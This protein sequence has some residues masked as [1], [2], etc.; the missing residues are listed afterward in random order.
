MEVIVMSDKTLQAKI[1]ETFIL[2][3]GA[4]IGVAARNEN[5]RAAQIEALIASLDTIEGRGALLITAT[6]AQ[7]QA[8]RLGTGREMARLVT[9]A[10]LDLH[11]KGGG[12]EEARKLL[13]FAKWIYEALP[14]RP[15]RVRLDQLTLQDLLKQLAGR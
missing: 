5:V 14:P 12:K 13:G 6:F 11:E 10:M 15:I 8:Q 3:W 9:Q 4:K 7:R 2:D 1:D